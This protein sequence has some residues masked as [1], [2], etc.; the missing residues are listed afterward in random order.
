MFTQTAEA[1]KMAETESSIMG[2]GWQMTVVL[3]R[4]ALG[5]RPSGLSPAVTPLAVGKRRTLR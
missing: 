1:S 5:S 2:M 4:L 3:P